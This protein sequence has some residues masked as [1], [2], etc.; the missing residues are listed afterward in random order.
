[1]GDTAN[2]MVDGQ[3]D[4]GVGVARDPS[5]AAWAWWFL[6]EGGSVARQVVGWVAFALCLGL[7]WV[8]FRGAGWA[9]AEIGGADRVADL[10]G[11]GARLAAALALAL[12]GAILAIPPSGGRQ[13]AALAVLVPALGTLALLAAATVSLYRGQACP[14]PIPGL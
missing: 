10:A 1:M 14:F 2:G 12:L 5:R 8:I 11:F 3:T 13:R 9:A 6:L 7:A 4:T